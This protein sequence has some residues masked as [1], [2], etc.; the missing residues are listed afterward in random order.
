MI[1]DCGI[2]QLRQRRGRNKQQALCRRLEFELFIPHYEKAVAIRVL[3]KEKA[4]DFFSPNFRQIFRVF[5][6]LFLFFLSIVVVFVLVWP[7]G[8]LSEHSVGG[9]IFFGLTLNRRRG[10]CTSAAMIL[11]C[12]GK[13]RRLR[14]LD[15]RLQQLGLK[16]KQM[17]GEG[18]Q[19]EKKKMM[20]IF[21]LQINLFWRK[22]SKEIDGHLAF[23]SWKCM[24]SY[25]VR[26]GNN[27]GK[28]I[29]SILFRSI[30]IQGLILLFYSIDQGGRRR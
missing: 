28:K 14:F 23:A 21:G 12:L 13:K 2:R 3:F 9:A 25:V 5:F 29:F 6:F 8:L 16:P 4:G 26:M 20:M 27:T 30:L 7:L 10:C 18:E 17:R 22:Y 24:C 19:E 11:A 1:R 15:A